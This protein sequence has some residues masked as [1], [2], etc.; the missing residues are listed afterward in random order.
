MKTYV[1]RDDFIDTFRR[2]S[3]YKNN[4][5]YDALDVLFEHLEQLEEDTQEDIDFDMVAIACEYSEYKNTDDATAL[6]QLNKAYDAEYETLE[7]LQADVIALPYTKSY[8]PVNPQ[9]YDGFVVQ[10]W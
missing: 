6:D 4:F 5:S 10:A 2:S 8:S 9:A 1:S 7:D 3:T